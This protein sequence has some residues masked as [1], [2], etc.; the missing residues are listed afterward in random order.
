MSNSYYPFVNLPLPYDYNALEPFIDE[1]TMYLHHSKHL[2]TY[3]N[4]LNKVIEEFP[5]LKKYSLSELIKGNFKIPIDSQTAL[6]NNAG[7]VYNHRFFFN[8]LTPK[9][10][11][12]PAGSLLEAIESSFGSFDKFKEEFTKV[13]LSVFGSGYAWLVNSGR[14]L[15]IITTK[16]QDSPIKFCLKPIITI[17]VWEHAYYLKHNNLRGEYIDNWFNVVDWE[18]ANNIYNVNSN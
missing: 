4:N 8:G 15:K 3:I 16:N 13:A 14:C 11:Q 12:K 17:D 2:N 10:Q 18:K 7:G 5:C 6:K 1:K 9:S